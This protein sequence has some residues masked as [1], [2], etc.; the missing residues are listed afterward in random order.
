MIAL[1]NRA[2][3]GLMVPIMKEVNACGAI[4]FIIPF[5]ILR[6]NGGAKNRAIPAQVRVAKA[7]ID[8]RAE[9]VLK[10]VNEPTCAATALSRW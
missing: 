2:N 4:T 1:T 10:Y 5:I 8:L 7:P 9:T 3:C 6:R